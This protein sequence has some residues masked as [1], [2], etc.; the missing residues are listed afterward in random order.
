MFINPKIAIEK[1]WIQGAIEQKYIQPNAID[2]T[3]DKLLTI[4]SDNTFVLSEKNKQMRG[5]HEMYA[6]TSISVDDD[7]SELYWEL[8]PNQTYDGMSNFYVNVPEGVAAYLLTRSTL[9]RNGLL[10]TS[11][12]YDSG[13]AGHIGFTLH[14]KNGKTLLAPGTRVGQIIFVESDSASLYAGGYNHAAGDHWSKVK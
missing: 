7:T 11:G 2:F 12:L 3:L 13:F 6:T 9:I 5:G 8:E 4:D 14:T 1:G 10:V